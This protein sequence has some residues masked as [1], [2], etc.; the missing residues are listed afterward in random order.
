M[1]ES[2]LTHLF[3]ERILPILPIESD[4]RTYHRVEADASFLSCRSLVLNVAV[5][6]DINPVIEQILDLIELI[7]QNEDITSTKLSDDAMQSIL[8]LLRLLSDTMEY[9][10]EVREKGLFDEYNTTEDTNS[11]EISDFVGSRYEKHKNI[12]KRYTVGFSV[13][14]S[15]FHTSEPTPLHSTLAMRLIRSCTN[16]KLNSKTLRVLRN[17]SEKLY[18]SSKVKFDE[19]LPIYQECIKQRKFPIYVQ[20]IDLTIDYILRFV[21]A[22]NHTEYLKFI[23]MKVID[24][25]LVKHVSELSLVKYLDLFGCIY[26]THKRVAHLLNT[27]KILSG[28]LKGTVSYSLLLYFTAKSF[29]YWVIARPREYIQLYHDLVLVEK[30]EA[31]DGYADNIPY[32]IAYL[33]DDIYLRFHVT[34]LL[35]LPP[36]NE[37]VN[38]LIMSSTSTAATRCS[39]T[40]SLTGT[41]STKGRSRDDSSV[42]SYSAR[43]SALAS[44]IKSRKRG[45]IAHLTI[46]LPHGGIS[47]SHSSR[48]NASSPN[49]PG[50]PGTPSHS[51]LSAIVSPRALVNDHP[52]HRGNMRDY[53]SDVLGSPNALAGERSQSVNSNR[54]S[55][56]NKFLS[57]SSLGSVRSKNMP[58]RADNSNNSNT[59][60]LA[61]PSDSDDDDDV[62]LRDSPE[63]RELRS[64]MEAADS[65]GGSSNAP[66]E[67]PSDINAY[68]LENVL[69]LF[70]NYN[71]SELRSTTT[72]LKFLIVLIFL[73]V[74]VLPEVNGLVFKGLGD[75]VPSEHTSGDPRGGDTPSPSLS[76]PLSTPSRNVTPLG[77]VADSSVSGTKAAKASIKQLT[78]NW[79][80]L[81]RLSSTSFSSGQG[82]T[83]SN[84]PAP[85]PT[86]TTPTSTANKQN[87]YRIRK[88]LVILIKNLNG[89]S[90]VS[91]TSLID[92]LRSLLTL[93]TMSS[94]ISLYDRR[95]PAVVFTRR[96][97]GLLG[98]TL[99]VGKK[100]SST[101]NAAITR[102]IAKN[103][104]IGK[105]LQLEFFAGSLQLDPDKFLHHLDLNGEL[106][107]MNM[108][109]LCLYTEGFRVSFYLLVKGEERRKVLDDLSSFLLL[110]FSKI[111][112]KLLKTSPY[113][114]E[115]VAAVITSVLDG[116]LKE[117]FDFHRY[118]INPN[119]ISTAVSTIASQKS[120][121]TLCTVPSLLD[122]ISTYAPVEYTTDD[123]NSDGQGSPD[124]DGYP[125][126]LSEILP[127]FCSFKETDVLT[128]TSASARATPLD[129]KSIIS[130]RS[131][132]PISGGSK[133]NNMGILMPKPHHMNTGSSVL[134]GKKP[135]PM[136]SNELGHVF[137][138]GPQQSPTEYAID[139]SISV[140]VPYDLSGSI[141]SPVNSRT[142]GNIEP[143]RVHT[144]PSTKGDG[145][146]KYSKSTATSHRT[147]SKVRD[148]PVLGAT[149]LPLRLDEG[150]IGSEESSH[151]LGNGFDR[152]TSVATMN[153]VGNT[154]YMHI[155]DDEERRI[156]MNIFSIMRRVTNYVIL[157]SEEIFGSI[158]DSFDIKSLIK[159]IFVAILDSNAVLQRVAQSFL[160]TL[161]VY[162]SGCSNSLKASTLSEHFLLCSYTITLFSTALYDLNITTKRREVLLEIIVKFLNVRA[163]LIKHAERFNF[164]DYMLPA[165]KVVTP[166]LITSLSGS[167]FISLYCNTENFAKLLKTIYGEIYKAILFYEEKIGKVNPMY[168]YST[169]FIEVM[170]K[171][172]GSTSGS[173]A[174]QR[175]LRNYILKYVTHSNIVLLQ[176]MD[177]I[178]R[179]WY[180]HLQLK[181]PTQR[182]IVDSRNLAGLFAAV[183]GVLSLLGD[184]DNAQYKEFPQ[185]VMVRDHLAEKLNFFVIRQCSWLNHPDLLTRENSR[186][187]ISIELHPLSFKLLFQQ[188]R[189]RLNGLF[190][191]DFS[192]PGEEPSFLLLEQIIITLRT[193][194]RRD[195]DEHVMVLFSIDFINL[196]DHLIDIVEKMSHDSFRYYKA[197][198]QMSKMYR[199]MEHSEDKL[200]IR[201]HF[202][203]KNRWIK[204]VI[205]WFDATI[206]K[207]YNFE[208]LSKPHREMNL[209]ERDLDLLYIDTSIESSNALAYLTKNVPLTMQP[210]STTEEFDRSVSAVFGNYFSILLKGLE[211]TTNLA[212][213][214]VVVRH[215]INL[216][217]EN[218][219]LS[220]TNLSNANVNAS[221]QFS[222]PMGYAENKNIRTAFLKVFIDIVTNYP[223]HETE[224]SKEKIMALDEYLQTLIEH[225]KMVYYG[226]LVC[227]SSEIDSY[228]A[229]VLSGFE[230]KNASHI[231]VKELIVNEIANAARYADVMR[232][233]SCG[234]RALSLYARSKGNDYLVK[235]LRPVLLELDESGEHFEI[236]RLGPNHPDKD[237]QLK[238]FVKYMD[239]LVDQIV[240]SVSYFPPE[241]LSICKTIHD[242][243]MDK[244]PDYAY[245]AVGSFVFLRFLGPALVS[246]ES[247]NVLTVC[248]LQSKRSFITLAKVIQNIAN[249]SDSFA[250]WPVLESETAFLKSCSVRIFDFLLR[251]CNCDEDVYIP[252]GTEAGA[253]TGSFDYNF[254]QK[255]IYQHELAIR[256]EL[257]K[258][259]NSVSDFRL[260]RKSI[261]DVDRILGIIGQPMLK[262]ENVIPA[263]IREN[264]DRYPELYEFMN[265][266]VLKMVQH[267]PGEKVPDFI[268][269]SISSDGTPV[270]L[271]SYKA[272]DQ[273]NEDVE[274]YVFKSFQVYSRI[275]SSRY[276][277]IFD[278]TGFNV[279]HQ[280]F[281]KYYTLLFSLLPQ[282]VVERCLRICYVNPTSKFIDALLTVI[283]QSDLY[284]RGNV[285]LVFLNTNSDLEA[286]R[287]LNCPLKG[288]DPLRNPRVSLHDIAM[289]DEKEKRY[290]PI[291][292]K[293][294]DRFFQILTD[295]P[296]RIKIPLI[297]KP[298]DV[299]L[300]DVYEMS[301]LA[302][303]QVSHTTNSPTEF[304]LTFL[305]GN[306]LILSSSKYLEITKMFTHALAALDSDYSLQ[307]GRLVRNADLPMDQITKKS[308]ERCSTICHLLLVALSGLF[309]EDD[310]I[311][312]LSFNLL[313]AVQNTFHLDLGNR[314]FSATE[315]YIPND[316]TSFLSS[317]SYSLSVSSPELT[318]YIWQYFL[319]A[320]E[321]GVIPR[322]HIPAIV[323]YLSYWVPNLYR[324]GYL[325]DDE[326]GTD[327]LTRTIRLLVNLAAREPDFAMVYIRQLWSRLA[328]D[329]R[330]S[331]IVVEEV[332]NSALERDSES[333][334]WEKVTSLL[335]PFQTVEVASQVVKRLISTMRLCLAS[336]TMESSTHSWSEITILSKL[337][338]GLFFE[339]PL[340]VQMYLP[341]LLFIISLLIDTGP[342]ELRLALY[343]LLINICYS[344]TINDS[345]TEDEEMKLKEI[346]V[347][348]SRQKLNLTSSFYQGKGISMVT[349][350]TPSFA[351][352]FATLEHFTTHILSLMGFGAKRE[353]IYWKRRYTYYLQDSLFSYN[354]ILSARVMMI[355]GVMGKQRSSELFCRDLLVETMKAFA[356]PVLNEET[357]FLTV[358]HI[359]TYSKIVEGLDSSIELVKQLFWFST[360]ILESEQPMQFESGVLFMANCLNRI[361]S[362]HLMNDDSKKSLPQVLMDARGFANDLLLE[363]ESL[364]GVVWSVYNFPHLVTGFIIRGLSIPVVKTTLL[365]CLKRLFKNSYREEQVRKT[366]DSS[367]CYLFT[368]YLLFSAEQFSKFLK[369]SD[370]VDDMV[371]LDDNNKIPR[372]LAEWL[373]SDVEC[374]N[375]ALYQGA[376]LFGSSMSDTSCK[377]RFTLIMR[378]LLRAKPL[379]L[380]RFYT[381]VREELARLSCMSQNN[382]IFLTTFDIIGMLITH[383]EYNYLDRF[384]KDSMKIIQ[385]RG[386]TMISKIDMFEN[387]YG[388]VVPPDLSGD[389]T[390]Y[391]RLRLI[392]KTLARIIYGSQ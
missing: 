95:I 31:V 151:K 109:R 293:I 105:R 242:S 155:T 203:L 271:V 334:D 315:I 294:N 392:T 260:A 327:F 321:S 185:L 90:S 100:W 364:K 57:L 268:Q 3:L 79:K 359:F 215:K 318:P 227:P 207:Q 326:D 27:V 385:D 120:T 137:L 391:Q 8:I 136:G 258:D 22:S 139:R 378:Y 366:D 6:K 273:I 274:I 196:I 265:K 275:W 179:K 254:F 182:E 272:F 99:E 40:S 388:C 51:S 221:L 216:L 257:L 63:P 126:D 323:C 81:S 166:I 304:T 162:L 33:F 101:K 152:G 276:Y 190:Y 353:C 347:F 48:T 59:A 180:A 235:T 356:R 11:E 56:P 357:L 138:S 224:S 222:L 141:H 244:F 264:I 13:H 122:R 223:K 261:M 247:E 20:K 5:F 74:H 164:L 296:K 130:T 232:R 380:F 335:V 249:G 78:Q 15:S 263:V 88:F 299:K 178:F 197:A 277:L 306:R 38:S 106:E 262:S 209:Q 189:Q 64:I 176:A 159:P 19:I 145:D 140:N 240:N 369:E 113:L 24:P 181:D 210:S 53:F 325:L 104:I 290:L 161:V 377:A 252:V 259:V 192:D 200:G 158:W 297:D 248:S 279:S 29:L 96:F 379:C 343:E 288:L 206:T 39:S 362:S 230:V 241:L 75:P 163:H 23:R 91:D 305:D 256:G 157:P 214:P 28:I 65:W 149:G 41:S 278:C 68:Y 76:T 21:A 281:K 146:I 382:D 194:L 266:T 363:L 127:I 243:V 316:A 280:I 69:E 42:V 46:S 171:D 102:C 218:V 25:L 97:Y 204:L 322:V 2:L 177:V 50:T 193:I 352:K 234:T 217:G 98:Q 349:F 384:T 174:F 85:T 61:V 135:S 37:S 368:I 49:T 9:Y 167:A 123:G 312:S 26:L 129:V 320:M 340:L 12:L 344:L 150:E 58:R 336:L 358:A 112:D 7:L 188:L 93:L 202:I 350:D 165:S 172:T 191:V 237:S 34:E 298:F 84:S 282:E 313:I 233:N 44:S 238:L 291:C 71:D 255:Y 246:P 83:S 86:S 205:Q 143:A 283:G 92:T 16:L 211:K 45:N 330:L 67:F 156:M 308:R 60:T 292:L 186:D 17:M 389:T 119:P 225:P 285:P 328:L 103:P 372:Q 115:N 121:T 30:G 371:F 54:S 317:V 72:V 348:F 228:T 387:T 55:T 301:N 311:N 333:R 118:N 116:P 128:T 354:S 270:L 110:L 251:L 160:D 134:L 114:D 73:D 208:N 365:E 62:M 212:R 284:F 184:A 201:N 250:K 239:K 169:K 175:S 147:I 307:G 342:V 89:T 199:A 231:I 18:N 70:S 345:L 374:S 111:S 1:V 338:V 245:I 319:D 133:P 144:A 168:I 253:T 373:S 125:W 148:H 94:S 324:Y 195:D 361:Y 226:S 289:Y 303:I 14:R 300:N 108:G 295:T 4:Y 360:I 132:T 117:K 187:I 351:S 131:T 390:T 286:L 47:L 383:E 381:V 43:D 302:S 229:A 52:T 370:Y 219:I 213:Y 386:L 375:I 346:S 153:L 367:F 355:L 124:S 66:N 10:W 170:A 331:E 329:D 341:E 36:E 154:E 309:Y 173:V 80:R 267:S 183:S 310:V 339:C 220:L 107:H 269:E 77:G 87:R 236:E 314:Y 142:A 32:L 287:E 35:S 332:I 337:S 82:K 198:I 376:L